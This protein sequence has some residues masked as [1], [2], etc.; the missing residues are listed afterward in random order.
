MLHDYSYSYPFFL[1]CNSFALRANI[2]HGT[3]LFTL[4]TPV[5]R[6]AK[7]LRRSPMQAT[8]TTEKANEVRRAY[9]YRS[10]FAEMT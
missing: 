10:T 2:K 8:G 4:P 5:P 7:G 1:W 3:R 9:R 6:E